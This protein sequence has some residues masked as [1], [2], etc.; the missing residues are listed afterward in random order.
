MKI[1]EMTSAE[2]VRKES[3]RDPEFQAEWDRTAFAGAVAL[4]VIGYRIDHQ[5]TQTALARQLGMKQPAVARL[6]SGDVTPSL[7]TRSRL[8]SRLGISFHTSPRKESP[9][10]S[11][12]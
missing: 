10:N 12:F 8:T 6:E 4:R 3:L 7:D 2:V 11:V 9:S 5:L 1:S